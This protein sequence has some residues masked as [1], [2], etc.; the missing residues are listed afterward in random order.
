MAVVAD[1]YAI[2]EAVWMVAVRCQELGHSDPLEPEKLKNG[3]CP[4]HSIVWVVD[5]SSF[6]LVE[7]QLQITVE[8]L[9]VV[10]EILDSSVISKLEDAVRTPLLE[11]GF[12]FLFG[13]EN[14]ASQ[15]LF[16]VVVYNSRGATFRRDPIPL[17]SIL[18]RPLSRLDGS[19]GDLALALDVSPR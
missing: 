8:L 9:D 1:R 3:R 2:G 11:R 19:T 4:L 10:V 17:E 18:Q 14:P 15:H 5:S 6:G 13:R 16:H 7:R 12:E